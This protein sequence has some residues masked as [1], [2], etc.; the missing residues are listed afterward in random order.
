MGENGEDLKT[1]RQ[2]KPTPDDT[3]HNQ[4]RQEADYG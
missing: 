2:V 4:P 1:C 3:N